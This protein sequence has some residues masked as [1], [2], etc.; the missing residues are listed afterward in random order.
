[1]FY[2][3]GQLYS[4]KLE[5]CFGDQNNTFASSCQPTPEKKGRKKERKKKKGKKLQPETKQIR[6]CGLARKRIFFNRNDDPSQKAD[7][8]LAAKIQIAK[9]SYN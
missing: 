4:V 2:E 8:K 5:L 7:G 6:A 1:M 3:T 9:Q